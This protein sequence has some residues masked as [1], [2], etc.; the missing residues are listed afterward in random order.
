MAR[1]IAHFPLKATVYDASG[2]AAAEYRFGNLPRYHAKSLDVSELLG[3]KGKGLRSGYGHV[4]IMYDFEAGREADGWLHGLFRYRDRVS[5]HAAE[6]SFG[7]H[8][9]NSVLVYKDEPQSYSGRAPGLTTRL[10]LRV[11]RNPTTR[12]VI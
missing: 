7:S 11:G 4:E 12:F 8:M 6:S 3:G 2:E 9:F 10:F 5:G 1:G